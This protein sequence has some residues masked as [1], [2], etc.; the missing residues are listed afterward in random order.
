MHF[1]LLCAFDEEHSSMISQPWQVAMSCWTYPLQPS[2][3]LTVTQNPAYLIARPWQV[4][5]S[6]L[7]KQLLQ[8]GT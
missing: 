4:R 3:A 8:P 5:L 7:R 1:D 2:P 6:S